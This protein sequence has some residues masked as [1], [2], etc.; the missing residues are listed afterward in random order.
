MKALVLAGGF[1]QI[2]LI[3]QLRERGIVTILAD[4]Y[5]EPVAKKYADKFYQVSTMDTDAIRQVAIDEKVD[6]LITVC[7]DQ[8]LNTIAR[9]SEDLGL[10]CYIDYQTALNVTNKQYM[11]KVFVENG[12]PTARHIILGEFDEKALEDLAFPLIVKPVDCNS[13]K[14]VAKVFNIDELE[15]A[16][17]MAVAYSRTS[18][19]I[20]EEY[21]EGP[22]LSVDVYVE[23]G[24][25][26]LL[27]VTTSDKIK[28]DEK[29]VI[30]R[31]KYPAVETKE[32]KEKIISAAQKIADAFNL[33]NSPML[34]QLIVRD[35]DI[36]IL[37]FSARTGG[38]VKHE[39]IKRISGFDAIKAVIDLTLGSFPTV[40]IKKPEK[41]YIVDEFVYCK[42]GVFDHLKNF[43]ELLEKGIISNYFLFKWP[44]AV[45][46]KIENSG[47]RIAGFTIKADT[48]EE[49]QS[50]HLCAAEELMVIDKTGQ[51]IMRHD[52]LTEIKYKLV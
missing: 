19:A 32:I 26:K 40:E 1:P 42:P 4:Y 30:F 47:D 45:F 23:Q 37:E 22:E 21:I 52:L 49:L 50:K 17:H 12:I 33:K 34:I 7:T 35:K 31:S 3:E 27:S 28:D 29:F 43:D 18:T 15:A 41:K 44:G 25:A 11:K 46:D 38:G 16:L 51:D 36:F 14:G 20:I 13:S 5:E 24:K 8:A 2:N 39:L 9:V 10:P 48:L 6:F